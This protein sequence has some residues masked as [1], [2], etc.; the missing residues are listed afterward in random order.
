[1]SGWV[2]VVAEGQASV[3]PGMLAEQAFK[4]LLGPPTRDT[5]ELVRRERPDAI[6][7]DCVPP[8]VSLLDFCR[9]VKSDLYV[10]ETP[11][12]MVTADPNCRRQAMTAGAD[13]F[14]TPPFD[15][16]ILPTR[17]RALMR[18]KQTIDAATLREVPV[19]EAGDVALVPHILIVED[20]E[21]ARDRLVAHIEA[22]SWRA[23]DVGDA[24]ACLAMALGGDVDLIIV[25]LDLSRDASGH[26][27]FELVTR[28]RGTA[29][30]R[31]LP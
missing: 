10:A 7:I 14:M 16:H 9:L 17:L 30:T 1:M 24:D 28:L 25:S 2:L 26:G 15:A 3:L 11:V 20:D 8:M 27:A 23:S 31:L 22:A 21:L 12:V 18:F 29:E 5:M 19:R 4:T 6:L 13:D